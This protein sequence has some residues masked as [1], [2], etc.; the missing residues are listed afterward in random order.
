MGDASEQAVFDELVASS[1]IP[2]QLGDIKTDQLP[3]M[4]ALLT[5]GIPA[6]VQIIEAALTSYLFYP[7]VPVLHNPPVVAQLQPSRLFD[8]VIPPLL[9]STSSPCFTLPCKMV[10]ASHF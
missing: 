5:P 9:L 6:L 3:G 4:E 2:A 8:V 10:L 7:P 1:A